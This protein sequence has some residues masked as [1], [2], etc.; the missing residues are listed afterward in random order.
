MQ[1]KMRFTGPGDLFPLLQNS[2]QMLP[3]PLYTLLMVDRGQHEHWLACGYVAPYSL[4]L[5]APCVVIHY[6]CDPD[7]NYLPFLPQCLHQMGLTSLVCLTPCWKFMV[8]P[9]SDPSQLVLNM[10]DYE[11]PTN[12]AMLEM[13]W[14]SSLAIWQFSSC[15]SHSGLYLWPFFLHFDYKYQMQ[16]IQYFIVYQKNPNLGTVFTS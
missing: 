5:D 2:V 15:Q 14:H 11:H 16:Y 9:S 7:Y 13:V 10:A 1:Q 4:G 8:F 6:S 3:Y 12:I